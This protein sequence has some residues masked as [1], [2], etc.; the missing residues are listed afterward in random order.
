MNSARMAELSDSEEWIDNEEVLYHCSD[1]EFDTRS[2]EE[3]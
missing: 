3:Q 2:D 1:S